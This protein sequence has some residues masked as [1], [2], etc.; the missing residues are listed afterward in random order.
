MEIEFRDVCLTR[1]GRRILDGVSF[2]TGD[3]PLFVVYGESGAGKSSLLRLVNRLSEPDS[4]DVLVSGRPVR[5]YPPAE[6]RKKVGMIFQEPRLLPGTVKANVLVGAE[7]HGLRVDAGEML[8][9]VGLPDSGERHVGDLSGGE[10]QRVA[11]ARALAVGPE[12][13]LMDEPTSALDERGRRGLEG[14]LKALVKR[15]ELRVVV[16]THDLSQIRRLGARGVF[17]SSGRVVHSGNLTG[18]L[19]GQPDRDGTGEGGAAPDV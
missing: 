3:Q 19:T 7:Y 8:S 5:D 1:G 4:G 10:K 15:G 12:L 14:V 6:L 17:L 11:I 2:G 13:L 18:Y 16:V 9:K